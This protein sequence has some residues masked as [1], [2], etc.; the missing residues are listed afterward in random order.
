MKYET[1]EQSS[2]GP[3][4][5]LQRETENI[6]SSRAGETVVSLEGG[7]EEKVARRKGQHRPPFKGGEVFGRLTVVN[8]SHY[9]GPQQYWHCLCECGRMT[10]V[11]RSD[12]FKAIGAT[13]SCGCWRREKAAEALT[14]HGNC[15]N[16]KTSGR[17]PEYRTWA[18]IIERCG[19]L[20]GQNFENYAGRGIK[21]CERWLKFEHFLEDMGCRPGKGYS[22]DR[23][24]NNGNYEPNNCRWATHAEQQRNKRNNVILT[25]DGFT[26]T[27]SEW[28]VRTGIHL[29]TI[30]ARLKKGWSVADT[31]TKPPRRRRKSL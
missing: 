22:I 29:A 16:A 2:A 13:V 15:K 6:D 11:G 30:C 8:F 3:R 27:Q 26:G 1:K 5:T 12:L 23:I 14:T 31:L 18:G 9:T 4:E 10:L 28:A 24:D 7:A 25:H 21:V 17:T 20:Q 19:N